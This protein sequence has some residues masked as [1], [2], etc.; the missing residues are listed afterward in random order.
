MPQ[1]TDALVV[2]DVQNDF[3][4]GGALAVAD[5][6]AV[7]APIN[8]M[9][10]AY[11]VRVLTQDWHPH[12]HRSFASNH[13]GA[14]PFSTTAMPYGAQ[15][16]WPTH[17]VQGT[18]GA[19]FHRHLR[20]DPADLVLRKGFRAAIDSYSAFVENDRTTPTGLETYLRGRGVRS[21][22]IVGLATDFCVAWSALDAIRCGFEVVVDLSACR[23][24]DLDGSIDRSI[25]AMRAA[26]VRLVGGG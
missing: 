13:P 4:P 2:V 23:G 10:E 14:A 22:T 20:T 24:I 17:C 3:C 7:V 12:D 25:A 6:D 18:H 16:L 26:G 15:V 19:A 8:A 11:P 21:I 1:P 5:G 9:I